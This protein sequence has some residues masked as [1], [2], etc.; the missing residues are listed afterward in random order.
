MTRTLTEGR[1]GFRS[2][3]TWT[4]LSAGTSQ[5]SLVLLNILL[6]RLVAPAEFADFL[7][8]LTLTTFIPAVFSLGLE[9]LGV[10]ILSN[11][12]GSERRSWL[13]AILLV[14]VASS[15]LAALVALGLSQTGLLHAQTWGSAGLVAVLAFAENCRLILADLPR[16]WNRAD[17]AA[18][19]SPGLPRLALVVV[20][21]VLAASDVTV[22]LTQA[23]AALALLTLAVDLAAAV[24]LM[25]LARVGD[26]PAASGQRGGIGRVG[27][28]RVVRMGAPLSGGNLALVCLNQ[29]DVL[30]VAHFFSPSVV[31]SY[32]LVSRLSNLIGNVVTMV[33]VALLPVLSRQPDSAA[34]AARQERTA[35]VAMTGLFAV[36]L[37][38]SAVALLAP[39]AILGIL[40]G[41]DLTDAAV[42]MPILVAGQLVN[43]ATGLSGSFLLRDGRRR[44][45]VATQAGCAAVLIPCVWAAGAAHSLPL[46][47]LA[48]AAGTAGCSVVLTAILF[49]TTRTRTWL[50]GPA[51]LRAS[52]TIVAEAPVEA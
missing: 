20:V 39:A 33:N 41:S 2:N 48:S 5:A 10:V 32:A 52:S 38:P 17:V 28:G 6:A 25:R 4:A 27:V 42:A 44:V 24:V 49:A 34:D 13:R 29:L 9:R 46:V 15:G 19:L 3:L 36:V 31:A 43:V 37:V 40:F 16:S 8:V 21:L 18:L 35:R 14:A 12:A 45:I 30:V 23:L 7:V 11:A 50:V 22:G 1:R 51:T 47:A 26:E